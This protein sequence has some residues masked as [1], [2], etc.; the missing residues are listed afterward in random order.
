MTPRILRKAAGALM[1]GMLLSA[2]PS[3]Y[4]SDIVTYVGC[5]NCVQ[6]TNITINNDHCAQV[7]N[8]QYGE[9]IVCK[10]LSIFGESMCQTSGGQCY[11]IDV[12]GG[13]GTKRADN[14]IT[15]GPDPTW[16]G[17]SAEYQSCL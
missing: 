9:G 14:N 8:N 2:S 6:Q 4:A 15:P 3:A 1:F 12:N 13:G 11:N 10:E 7:G 16:G 17:C 5:L